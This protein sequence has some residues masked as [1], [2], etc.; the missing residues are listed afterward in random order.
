M[1]GGGRSPGLGV[2]VAGVVDLLVPAGRGAGPDGGGAGQGVRA[3]GLAASRVRR[4]VA[5]GRESGSAAS[6]GRRR[7]GF[8]TKTGREV[9]KNCL[10]KGGD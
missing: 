5:V 9:G 3:P 2:A 1:A 4:R 7:R 8:G 6:R 10:R